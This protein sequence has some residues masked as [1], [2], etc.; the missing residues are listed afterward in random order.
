[1]PGPFFSVVIPLYNKEQ[2]VLAAL[3]SVL[4]QAQAELEVIVIDDGSTDAG[5]ALVHGLA[6][7]R[8]TLIQQA[9]AG[10]AAARNRGLEAAHGEYVCFL[11]ADDQYRPGFLAAMHQLARQFPDA[12]LLCCGY[13]AVWPDG[14]HKSF[15]RRHE[16]PGAIGLVKDFYREWAYQPFMNASGVAIKRALLLDGGFRF[17]VGEK[18]GEDQDLWFRLA[19]RTAVAHD[20]R[21]LVAY[22]QAVPNSATTGAVVMDMLPCYQRLAQRLS[23]GAVPAP[24]RA[25]ARRLLA[26]HL[27]NLARTNAAA[28]EL[29]RAWT[30][31][32]SPAARHNPLYWLRSIG[33]VGSKGMRKGLGS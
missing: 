6:E 24:M 2:F 19:E 11:D 20:N 17:A 3:Q 31:L 28:G 5:P 14:Q 18:L 25:G 1:M 12:G 9:N 27:I 13:E 22:T 33:F 32:L 8:V 21:P 29:R 7:P 16:S 10:V 15:L 26:S 4:S 30:M 23:A